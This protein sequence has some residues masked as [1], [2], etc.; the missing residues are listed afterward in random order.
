[1][2]EGGEEKRKDGLRTGEMRGVKRKGTGEVGGGS[3]PKC[4]K[5]F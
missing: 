3:F 5:L 4:T 1:M 2:G